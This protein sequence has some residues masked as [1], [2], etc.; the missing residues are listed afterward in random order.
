MVEF[1]E[2]V[3]ARNLLEVF[4]HEIG[5]QIWERWGDKPLNRSTEQQII[6]F[7]R[8]EETAFEDQEERLLVP[9]RVYL[10]EDSE[11]VRVVLRPQGYR[12]VW[13]DDEIEYQKTGTI[14]TTVN[15]ELLEEVRG[16]IFVI[17]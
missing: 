11:G 10:V 17:V 3:Y 7:V 6:T 15:R 12:N 2:V 16:R 1:L 13:R 4:Y 14:V 9:A 8:D 5:R